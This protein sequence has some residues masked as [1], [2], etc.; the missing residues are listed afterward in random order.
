MSLLR[1]VQLVD[2]QSF[3]PQPTDVI[4]PHKTKGNQLKINKLKILFQAF[5]D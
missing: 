4:D 1:K 5:T 3:F 2:F